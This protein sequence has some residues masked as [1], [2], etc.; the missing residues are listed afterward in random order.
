MTQLALFEPAERLARRKDPETSKHAAE[1]SVEF[2]GK[3]ESKIFGYLLDHPE[4]ATYRQIA[5][6]TNLEPVAVARRMKGLQERAG[7]YADGK[8]DGMQVWKV[9]RA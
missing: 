9:S 1:R 7:V 8:R 4:G 6:G 5:A 2:R 3:H